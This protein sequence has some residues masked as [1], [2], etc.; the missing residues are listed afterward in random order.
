MYFNDIQPCHQSLWTVGLFGKAS[1][2]LLE[3]NVHLIHFQR[4]NDQTQKLLDLTCR[5]FKTHSSRCD[6]GINLGISHSAVG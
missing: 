6:T 3:G 1:I 4:L 5:D 2:W